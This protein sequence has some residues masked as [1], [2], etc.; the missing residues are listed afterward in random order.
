MI[1]T[2]R[3]ARPLATAA[4]GLALTA[5]LASGA[6]ARGGGGR[7]SSDGDSLDRQEQQNPIFI[8]PYGFA[9]P[10]TYRLGHP[11]AGYDERQFL[12]DHHGYVAVRPYYGR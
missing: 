5:A 9:N 3:L 2:T 10:A 11:R 1:V 8:Q 12:E 6:F 7:G 4:L